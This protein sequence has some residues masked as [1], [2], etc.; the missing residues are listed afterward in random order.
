MIAANL[1]RFW[2]NTF[3]RFLL[4]FLADKSVTKLSLTNT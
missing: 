3:L 4:S 2:D 1:R